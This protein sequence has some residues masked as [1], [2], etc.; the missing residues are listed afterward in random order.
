MIFFIKINLNNK[1]A[2]LKV[3]LLIKEDAFLTLFPF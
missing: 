3:K 1:N 2:L